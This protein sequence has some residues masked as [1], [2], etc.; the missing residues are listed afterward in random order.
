M[1]F[2][3]AQN[4]VSCSDADMQR[5]VEAGATDEFDAF[6]DAE[7]QGVESLVQ[8]FLRCDGA[9]NR[10]FSGFQAIQAMSQHDVATVGK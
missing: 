4:D 3:A 7:T 6:P 5:A 1:R 2:G 8:A 10:A 9:N